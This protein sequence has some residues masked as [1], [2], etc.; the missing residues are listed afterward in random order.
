MVTDEQLKALRQATPPSWTENPATVPQ[1]NYITGLVESRV[2]PA[3]WLL[4]IKELAEQPGGIKKGKAG[5]IIKALKS[6]PLQ[7]GKDDRSQINPSITDI[8]PGRYCI[9]TG[10]DKND[11]SFYHVKE[12]TSQ[13]TGSKYNI[14]IKIAGP[15]EYVLRGPQAKNIAKLIHRAGIGNAAALYGFKIGRC[16]ICHTQI[17]KRLSRELGI[18]PVCGGRV[19]DDWETRVAN[20]RTSLQARGLDPDEKVES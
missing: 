10:P 19:Y 17:T 12:V 2:V 3:K 14:L 16:S 4:R 5:E 18:G 9:Q 1:L 6:L 11:L 7:Q 13:Q 8:P 15:N 20:A